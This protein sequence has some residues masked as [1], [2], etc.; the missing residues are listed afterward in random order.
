MHRRAA[1][2]YQK[3]EQPM[4]SIRSAAPSTRLDNRTAARS[5]REIASDGRN[6]PRCPLLGA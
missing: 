5:K 2:L 3:S 6:E 4:W 1:W